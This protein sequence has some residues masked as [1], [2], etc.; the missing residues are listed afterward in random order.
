MLQTTVHCPV[1]PL[2]L[3]LK[4]AVVAVPVFSFGLLLS[5]SPASP[6]SRFLSFLFPPLPLSLSSSSSSPSCW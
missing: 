4:P 1:P 3:Q 6:S 5:F 2:P